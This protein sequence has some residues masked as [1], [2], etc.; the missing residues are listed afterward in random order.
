MS[1]HT[2]PKAIRARCAMTGRPCKPERDG[3]CSSRSGPASG[4]PND[5][6]SHASA[7]PRISG[8]DSDPAHD[9]R[10]RP[11]TWRTMTQLRQDASEIG[12]TEQNEGG[13]VVGMHKLASL[14]TGMAKRRQVGLPNV[15]PGV[16]MG[17][18]EVTI[19]VTHQAARLA[20][21]HGPEADKARVGE[22]RHQRIL[23]TEYPCSSLRLTCPG[24]ARAQ[25]N[26]T[27]RSEIQ[28]RQLE[29]RQKPPRR[30]VVVRLGLI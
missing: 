28:R 14:S 5:S 9:G 3:G 13:P 4:P 18:D 29:G 22:R 30:R 8:I 12:R 15:P 6:L 16:S 1:L 17:G 10:F 24:F 19:E 21:R 25:Y 27:T 2:G 7:R 20:I 11:L 26:E 23:K